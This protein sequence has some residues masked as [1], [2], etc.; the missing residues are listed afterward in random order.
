MKELTALQW[1]KEGFVLNPEAKGI[2]KWTNRSHTK[3]AVYYNENEVREDKN[4]AQDVLRTKKNEYREAAKDRKQRYNNA[5]SVR[6]KMKT[7]FQWLQEGRIPDDKA[8]WK[9]GETLNETFNLCAYGSKFYYC[10]IDD[11]HVPQNRDELQKAIN[12]YNNK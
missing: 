1:A 3:K 12:N 10:H 11:T 7:E 5:M 4:T 8:D 6:D 9:Y 2:E